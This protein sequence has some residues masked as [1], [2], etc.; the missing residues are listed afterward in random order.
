[1][2]LEPL[3]VLTERLP[4]GIRISVAQTYFQTTL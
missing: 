4:F 1:M 2:T 3:P